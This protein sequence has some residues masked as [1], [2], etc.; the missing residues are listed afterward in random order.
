M[1]RSG[2]AAV[3]V[4][5]STLAAAAADLSPRVWDLYSSARYDE[6]LALLDTVDETT[7]ASVERQT[8]REYRMLCLMALGRTDDATAMAGRL[9]DANPFYEMTSDSRPPRVVALLEQARRERLPR[10]GQQGYL[11][12]TTAY[13]EGRY[14]DAELSLQRVLRIVEHARG[15]TELQ[16]AWLDLL[17]ARAQRFLES[18]RT[19]TTTRPVT[20]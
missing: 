10:L 6:A 18:V 17:E 7:L 14:A 13:S 8:L 12:A 5:L 20:P 19:H 16:D 3:V 11:E 2:L 4:L 9:I 1:V 15:G